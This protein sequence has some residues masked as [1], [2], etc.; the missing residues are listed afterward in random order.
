MLYRKPCTSNP[1]PGNTC[2][3]HVPSPHFKYIQTVFYYY[4]SHHRVHTLVTRI[5]CIIWNQVANQIL[6]W[7]WL[8]KLTI[9]HLVTKCASTSYSVTCSRHDFLCV[10]DQYV[11]LYIIDCIIVKLIMCIITLEHHVLILY[12]KFIS[13]LNYSIWYNYSIIMLNYIQEKTLPE[14]FRTHIIYIIL[15]Y[16]MKDYRYYIYINLTDW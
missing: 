14:Q 4:N 2:Y 9:L 16:I 7:L 8:Y 1:S 6:G 15:Y 12:T 5:H 13:L 11:Q 3:L 10:E